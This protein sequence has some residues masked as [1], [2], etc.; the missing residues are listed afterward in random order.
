MMKY[1][2]V[3]VES[4]TVSLRSIKYVF[5]KH[6]RDFHIAVSMLKNNMLEDNMLEGRSV[7]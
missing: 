1:P 2:V 7:P 3:D 4:T 5:L 6:E